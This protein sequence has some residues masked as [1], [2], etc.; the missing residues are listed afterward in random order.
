MDIIEKVNT[1]LFRNIWE[2]ARIESIISIIPMIE[3]NSQI[4]DIGTENKYFTKIL[5]DFMK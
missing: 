4:E 5:S 2:F 1:N 3:N